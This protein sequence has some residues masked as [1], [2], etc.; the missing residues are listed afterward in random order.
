MYKLLEA[1]KL[2]VGTVGLAVSPVDIQCEQDI[3]ESIFL[4]LLRTIH[5]LTLHQ[6][7][8]GELQS[9]VTRE[10]RIKVSFVE[11]GNFYKSFLTR[12]L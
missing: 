1:Y 4:E 12:F 9:P 5:M 7:M 10:N 2:L 8:E 3:L 6:H 11:M